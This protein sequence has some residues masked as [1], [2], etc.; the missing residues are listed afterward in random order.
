MILISGGIQD[1]NIACLAQTA[2]RMGAPF[3]LAYPTLIRVDWD[4]E[5]D[6]KINGAAINPKAFFQRFNVFGYDVV[7][8]KSHYNW[9]HSYYHFFRSAALAKQWKMFDL[10]TRFETFCKP[11]ELYE[12]RKIGLNVASTIISNNVLPDDERIFKPIMGGEHT[13]ILSKSSYHIG[14]GFA[15]KRL[16]GK[17]YRVY[18]IGDELMT[19]RMD[20]KSLDY[21]EKQDVECVLVDN[22]CVKDIEKVRELSHARGLHFSASDLKED[23]NGKIHFLEINSSPMFVR[24]DE[25]SDGRLTEKM[26]QWLIS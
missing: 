8:N 16:V 4:L 7:N 25:A 2:S 26:I 15:Q 18:V 24:F 19:F 12:A 3:Q 17:E 1:P 5:G 13:T 23:E 6:V 11:S 14:V 20:T 22:S 9:Y 10:G 21:R